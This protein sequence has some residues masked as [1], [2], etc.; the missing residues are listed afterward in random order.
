MNYK[1]GDVVLYIRDLKYFYDAGLYEIV[2]IYPDGKIL[3]K[4]YH[5]EPCELFH[6]EIFEK[7]SYERAKELGL[8]TV[9]DLLKYAEETKPEFFI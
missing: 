6:D 5:G 7:M 2:Y 8:K 3:A 9:V 1:Y 4:L